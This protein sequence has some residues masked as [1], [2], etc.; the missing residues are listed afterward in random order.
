MNR[1]SAAS[2]EELSE[3]EELLTRGQEDAPVMTGKDLAGLL[4]FWKDRDDIGDSVEFARKLREQSNRR[5][6]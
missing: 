6:R 1:Q 5:G 4:G 3:L 2:V